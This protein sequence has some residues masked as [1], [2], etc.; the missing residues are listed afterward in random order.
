[1]V[2]QLDAQG[3]THHTLPVHKK[4][5]RTL[6]LVPAVRALI[7]EFDVVHVRSRMP[8]WVTYLAW[9]KL[10]AHKRPTLVS[11]FHGLYSINRYSAVM[12]RSQRI[13][14]ISQCV[15]D[16]IQT[17][18]GV[19]ENLI[20]LIHR[21][22]D[23]QEFPRDYQMSDAWQSAWYAE[24][25][26]RQGRTF[27][28]LPGRI[29]RWKGAEAFLRL[30]STLARRYNVHG[31]LVGDIAPGKQKYRHE[32]ERLAWQLGIEDRIEITGARSDLKDIYALSAI[33]FN[34]STHPE[35]FGRTMIEALSMGR[36]VVAWDYG[37]AAESVGAL[38]PDGVVPPHDEAQL[39][40]CCMRI[41]NQQHQP[42]A[43]NTFLLETM[44]RE[45]LQV[46]AEAFTSKGQ[47]PAS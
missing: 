47:S 31:L 2:A 36:P 30:I 28:T 25:P 38:F 21:G 23:P 46:Y 1:M 24:N 26:A 11:T 10:P 37:G 12:A 22:V 17:N 13:I 33:T 40:A 20:R 32:L 18:Y 35:P 7:Q 39:A 9:R 41:L 43:T 5:L 4:S 19:E 42:P 45:T 6:T 34:L 27:L 14:A 8:A 16:Y 15:K 29:T 44:R 3:T